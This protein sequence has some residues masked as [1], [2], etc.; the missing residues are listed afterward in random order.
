MG[1]FTYPKYPYKAT[2]DLMTQPRQRRPLVIVGA[3]PVGL[4]AAID[5]RL[6]GLEVLL[7]AWVSAIRCA[8]RG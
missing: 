5:A 2:Q 7:T 6:Q 8:R 4:A 3:G 1:Q